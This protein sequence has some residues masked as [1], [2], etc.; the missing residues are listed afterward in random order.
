MA[1]FEGR[2]RRGRDQLVLEAGLAGT[3][4]FQCWIWVKQTEMYFKYQNPK[5]TG[6]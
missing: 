2:A 1:A 5:L 4:Q 3:E 6:H